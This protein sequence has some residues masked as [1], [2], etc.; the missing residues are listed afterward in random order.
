MALRKAWQKM[1]RNLSSEVRQ[2]LVTSELWEIFQAKDQLEVASGAED[3]AR[4]R[5]EM[6][7]ARK[8]NDF[9]S[10]IKSSNEKGNLKIF[11]NGFSLYRFLAFQFLSLQEKK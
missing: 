5:L 6:N 8:R 2:S 4:K 1:K 11:I 7:L 9:S 3:S 10:K